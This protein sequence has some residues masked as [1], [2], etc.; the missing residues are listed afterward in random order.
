MD[1]EAEGVDRVEAVLDEVAAQAGGTLRREPQV[2]REMRRV[3][4]R[5]VRDELGSQ[6]EVAL[7]EDDGTLRVFGNWHR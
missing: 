3:V 6:S 2:G 4:L 1:G 7:R 5:D